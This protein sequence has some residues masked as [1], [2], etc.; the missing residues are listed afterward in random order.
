M[1]EI[2]VLMIQKKCITLVKVL[3]YVDLYQVEVLVGTHLVGI[4]M[5]THD[6]VLNL[7]MEIYLFT[8]FLWVIN[9]TFIHEPVIK[10]FVKIFNSSEFKKGMMFEIKEELLHVVKDVH[11]YNHQE[12][13]VIK[14]DLVS[15]MQEK[16]DMLCMYVDS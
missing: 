8:N 12:I 6:E 3:D 9:G 2:Q 1:K 15:C 7:D 14:S 13:K 5:G 10:K 16:D 11:S 4:V